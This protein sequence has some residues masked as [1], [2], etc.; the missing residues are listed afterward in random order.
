MNANNPETSADLRTL[1]V[2]LGVKVKA[3]MY[4]SIDDGTYQTSTNWLITDPDQSDSTPNFDNTTIRMVG[5]DDSKARH[6]GTE[7]YVYTNTSSQVRSRAS[8]STADHFFR[9]CTHGWID[10]RGRNIA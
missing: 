1:T 5:F 6:T 4:V 9:I 3:V 7:A 10:P 2:P 8:A